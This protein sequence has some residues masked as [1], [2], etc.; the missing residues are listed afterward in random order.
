VHAAERSVLAAA[1]D[2]QQSAARERPQ[3][4]LAGS[5]GAQASRSA[6]TSSDGTTWTL[7]PL[8][9]TFPLWDGG[10]R[11]AGTAAARAA[12]DEAVAGYQGTLRRALREVESALVALDSASVRQ[13]D[14]EAA[15]RDFEASLR[16]TEARW[17]GGLASQFELEDAR[18][19]ALAAQNVLIE[20]QRERASAWV[21]L[22][23]AL[24]GG[25]EPGRALAESS[26]AQR[27]I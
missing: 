15:A 22:W 27:P 14:A 21:T 12:Y 26:A 4:V 9:V 25:F 23:R 20:L 3:I 6:G 18:R 7:G 13:A 16:A 19:S 11:R 24:G 8:A 10:A 17:R 5:L 1:A 2:Q